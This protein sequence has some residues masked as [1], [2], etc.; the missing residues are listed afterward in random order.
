VTLRGDLY[1]EADSAEQAEM[2]ANNNDWDDP[3]FFTRAE[4][5][6]WEVRGKAKAAD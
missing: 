5:T 2:L 4:M 3:D 1:V 6:D